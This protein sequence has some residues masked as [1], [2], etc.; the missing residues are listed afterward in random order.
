[1]K[2]VI[3]A[4]GYGTRLKSILRDI[5][6]PMAEVCGKPFLE[7]LI[8]D[9]K[10]F[11]IKDIVLA[12]AYKKEIIQ[13]YF[14]NGKKFGVKIFYAQQTA[15]TGTA[16]AIKSAEKYL[17]A[18]DFLILNG[19]SLIKLDFKPMLQ[20]HKQQNG[21]LTIALRKVKNYDRGGFAKLNHDEI[22][23]FDFSETLAKPKTGLINAG[24]YLAK[25]ELF[26]FIPSDSSRI[27]SLEKDILPKLFKAKQKI[28]GYVSDG[29]FIDIGTP[30]SYNKAQT[31][32]KQL[33][34][35]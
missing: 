35:L 34:I 33:E 12:V 6:K 24:V 28:F 32:F 30:K 18:E 29:Y 2:A 25:P 4:A 10:N 17:K 15:P 9:L 23:D 5:P 22:I 3:L 31:D 20:F 7:Y 21:I 1:M 16:G 14:Q 27:I 13:T 11:G 26:H 19:D 8:R